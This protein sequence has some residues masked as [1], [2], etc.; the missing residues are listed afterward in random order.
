LEPTKPYRRGRGKRAENRIV[1]YSGSEQAAL[2]A[3]LEKVPSLKEPIEFYFKCNAD[4]R[5]STVSIRIKHLVLGLLRYIDASGSQQISIASIDTVFIAGLIEWLNQA[6]PK[7]GAAARVGKPLAPSTK[8]SRFQTFIGLIEALAMHPLHSA[9]ARRILDDCVPANPWPGFKQ[10]TVPTVRLMNDEWMKIQARAED[11]VLR[12]CA[13]IREQL[14]FM[15]R[16]GLG[17]LEGRKPTIAILKNL[18]ACIAYVIQRYDGVVPTSPELKMTDKLLAKALTFHTRIVV[19][20]YLYPGTRDVVPFV[21]L[22]SIAGAFNPEPLFSLNHEDITLDQRLGSSIVSIKSKKF[23]AGKAHVTNLPSAETLRVNIP[24]LLDVL[25][26]WT[27]RLRSV[28]PPEFKDRVFVAKMQGENVADAFD[29]SGR[30]TN[31]R[32]K[33]HGA[34]KKFCD[35]SDIEYSNIGQLRK[36][37]IDEVYVRTGSIGD[38][39]EVANHSHTDTTWTHYTSDGTRRRLQERLAEVFLLKQRYYDSGLKIDPRR[40]KAS[41]QFAAT[42]GFDCLDPF[43]SPQPTQVKG[44]L[45]KA[46]G[47]CPACPMSVANA[48]VVINVAAYEAL[49][50]KV[51]E[52]AHLSPSTWKAVWA[53][54]FEALN[55]LLALVPEDVRCAASEIRYPMPSVG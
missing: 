11:E 32:L 49:R 12:S 15:I 50:T 33:W 22:L 8:Y 3:A 17:K 45:C 23:R 48:G 5:V 36:S 20:R 51:L 14:P 37:D 4:W 19:E 54:V 2:A 29:I 6:T 27:L 52:Q 44:T 26:Q 34:L 18:D 9:E 53:S 13:M 16:T 7:S 40:M 35:S 55:G 38:A 31:F 43:D 24:L 21:I 39:A 25:Y 30:S 46:F 47:R 41:D 1:P 28:L 42:P 10:K